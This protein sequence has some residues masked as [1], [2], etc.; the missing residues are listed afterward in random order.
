MT[1]SGPVKV[2]IIV[3]MTILHDI[4]LT[5]ECL[6]HAYGRGNS[7]RLCCSCCI[8]QHYTSAWHPAV[9]TIRMYM[10]CMCPIHRCSKRA[11]PSVRHMAGLASCLCMLALGEIQCRV[12]CL[13][14]KRSAIVLTLGRLVSSCLESS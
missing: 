3:T 9:L 1:K 8:M 12:S 2:H 13:V 14:L 11:A 6:V 7:G 4:R 10:R 5:Q